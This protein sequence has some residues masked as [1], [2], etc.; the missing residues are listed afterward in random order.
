MRIAFRF[1]LIP[2]VATMLL[3]ALGIAL[4]QWQTRRAD[5]KLAMQ[6]KVAAA[7]TQA[8]LRLDGTPVDIAQAEWR[9]VS[10]SGTF[11][12]GWPVYLD[13]R[14]QAGRAGLYVLMPFRID[15]SDSHVLVLRGWLPVDAAHRGRIAP[16]A[17]PARRVTLEGIARCDPGHV[18]GLGTDARLAPGAIVLNADVAGVATASGLRFQPFVLQQ[19]SGGT[20]TL[21]RDWPAPALGIEKHRG[22]AFQWYALALT[23]FLFFV[24]TGFLSG[25][26]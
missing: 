21:V 14:P 13:N 1:K 15:G 18:L 10:V 19:T 5:D 9:R 7:N 22:Y 8:P 3:V 26:K 4:G 23:A 6:A 25:R 16:Y 11:V 2:F 24:I 17:T 12:A 20:D